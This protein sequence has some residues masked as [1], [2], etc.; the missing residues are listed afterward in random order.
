MYKHGLVSIFTVPAILP[1]SRH[2]REKRFSCWAVCTGNGND[3]IKPTLLKAEQINYWLI[4]MYCIKMNCD[5]KAIQVTKNLT[6]KWDEIPHIYLNWLIVE[7]PNSTDREIFIKS[8]LIVLL[9]LIRTPCR[10]M[11]WLTLFYSL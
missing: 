3:M 1:L 6:S 4:L 9:L 11:I 7:L 8:I 2:V 5:I 10:S